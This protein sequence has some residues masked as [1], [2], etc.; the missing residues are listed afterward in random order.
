MIVFQNLVLISYRDAS[1]A[2]DIKIVPSFDR[3]LGKAYDFEHASSPRPH[4]PL[5]RC[6]RD[7]FYHSAFSLP[8]SFEC[9]G[10]QGKG[11]WL[12][13]EYGAQGG[14]GLLSFTYLFST[15]SQF[16]FP[17]VH[18]R[19]YNMPSDPNQLPDDDEP[20]RQV[21]GMEEGDSH[22]HEE[23][24][25]DSETF[26]PLCL[27]PEQLKY[28][29]DNMIP[30]ERGE[31]DERVQPPGCAFYQRVLYQIHPRALLRFSRPTSLY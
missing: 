3:I 28:L 6:G 13:Y 10:A 11:L 17:I 19:Y 27:K 25:S 30:A 26:E 23:P 1:F 5:Y 16:V 2:A 21:G 12:W 22:Y 4:M 15:Q 24:N 9:S 14:R 7:P 18:P 20:T 31:F 29:D 8:R